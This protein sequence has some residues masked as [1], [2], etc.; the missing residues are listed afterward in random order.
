MKQEYTI[1][2]RCLPLQERGTV[3]PRRENLLFTFYN[4]CPMKKHVEHEA[5]PGYD[6]LATRFTRLPARVT[7]S[8]GLPSRLA[9]EAARAGRGGKSLETFTNSRETPAGV[10]RLSTRVARLS[11]RVA[12][13]STGVAR[14]STRVSRLPGESRDFQQESRDYQRESRDFRRES[15][16]SRVIIARLSMKVAR[17]WIPDNHFFPVVLL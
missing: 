14:L 3:V 9:G 15:R 2:T 10:A 5:R 7:A 6:P 1:T 17:R 8:A 12:S 16:V 13:L 4:I 11:T